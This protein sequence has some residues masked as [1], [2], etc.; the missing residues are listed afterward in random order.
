MLDAFIA[1]GFEPVIDAK[2]QSTWFELSK[3][4]TIM[5]RKR[6]ASASHVLTVLRGMGT[7]QSASAALGEKAIVFDYPKPVELL[8]YLTS[9]STKTDSLILDFF[10]GSRDARRGRDES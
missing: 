8:E 5:M 3:S 7:V 2:G 9:V 4:G 1:G 6:R 10:A